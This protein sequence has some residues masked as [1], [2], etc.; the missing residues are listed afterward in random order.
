MEL[1][2]INHGCRRKLPFSPT[3]LA[4]WIR[5]IGGYNRG[6]HIEERLRRVTWGGSE[7]GMAEIGHGYGGMAATIKLSGGILRDLGHFEAG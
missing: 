3:P 2:G 1:G 4:D 6:P 5:A 7:Q